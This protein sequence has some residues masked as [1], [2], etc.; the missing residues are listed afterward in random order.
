[1]SWKNWSDHPIAVILSIVVSAAGLAWSMYTHST[2]TKNSD[3]T[4]SPS[5]PVIPD[6]P[7]VPSTEV[8]LIVQTEQFAPLENVEVR[9]ITKGAPE[10]RLTDSNGY[11]RLQIP[12]TG[13]VEVILAKKDFETLRLVINLDNDSN[14]ARTYQLKK[15]TS[16]SSQA[17]VSSP[18]S[19]TMP[20]PVPSPSLPQNDNSQ[21]ENRSISRPDTI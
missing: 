11:T 17:S 20:E 1:M 13:D 18:K 19:S 4:P 2:S 14:R 6:P 5:T 16:S 21:A 12:S 15:L 9:F 8:G 7:A 3:V 10:V